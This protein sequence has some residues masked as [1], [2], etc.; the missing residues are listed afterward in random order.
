MFR[1]KHW[2]GGFGQRAARWLT[3]CAFALVLPLL[4]DSAQALGPDSIADVAEQ[5]IDAVVN[6]ATSQRLR[7]RNTTQPMPFNNPPNDG[8]NNPNDELFGDFFNRRGPNNQAGNNPPRPVN[9]LG[10]GFI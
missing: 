10:S 9:S 7:S 4:T 1:T 8:S 3:L 5:V 6:I 2:H